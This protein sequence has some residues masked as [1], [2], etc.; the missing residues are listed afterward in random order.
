MNNRQLF[1]NLVPISTPHEFYV[2]GNFCTRTS[3]VTAKIRRK[4]MIDGRGDNVLANEKVLVRISF[5]V[6][7]IVEIECGSTT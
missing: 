5:V 3:N 7:D 2:V 6:D 1:L 4:T